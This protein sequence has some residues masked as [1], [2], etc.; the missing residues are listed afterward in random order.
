MFSTVE[1]FFLDQEPL[2][3]LG[4]LASPNMLAVKVLEL[5]HCFGAM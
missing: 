2:E 3:I 5:P 1:L 4:G